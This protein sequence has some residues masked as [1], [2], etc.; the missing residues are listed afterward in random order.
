M[1]TWKRPQS[2]LGVSA[3]V[4]QSNTHARPKGRAHVEGQETAPAWGNSL[5][6]AVGWVQGNQGA[7]MWPRL[8]RKM[9]HRENSKCNILV[10]TEAMGIHVSLSILHSKAMNSLLLFSEQKI[11]T[12]VVSVRFPNSQ[13]WVTTKS[14]SFLLYYSSPLCLVYVYMC[15]C[16]WACVKT[17]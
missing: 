16:G 3:K 11:D 5:C 15:L 14:E 13:P 8:G 6:K 9:S 10:V 17:A 7:L 12:H 4:S 2:G 1:F